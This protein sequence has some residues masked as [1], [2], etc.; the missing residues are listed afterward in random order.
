ML[1]VLIIIICAGRIVVGIGPFIKPK[2]LMRSFQFPQGH[3]N[4]TSIV[5]SRLFGVRDIFLGVISIII[6]Y[7][8]NALLKYT[9]I[10]NAVIDFSDAL[11]FFAEKTNQEF[12]ETS[13][14][15]TIFAGSV[16]MLWIIC[17]IFIY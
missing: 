1:T 17:F 15:G 10:I 9:L 5:L 8:Y 6:L 16:G 2:L 14:R 4:Q 12:R 13:I 3:E 11:I 7:K